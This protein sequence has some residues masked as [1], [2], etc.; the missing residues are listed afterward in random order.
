M[1]SDEKIMTNVQSGK[2]DSISILYDRY[3]DFL[4]NYFYRLCS[5]RQIS[6]DLT[7]NVFLRI[8][9][10]KTSFDNKMSFKSWAF[11]IARNQFYDYKDKIN[12]ETE[13]H[14]ELSNNNEVNE[15]ISDSLER[16]ERLENALNTLPIETKEILVL[17]KY[18]NFKYKDLAD[19][20][21]TSEGAIKVKIHRGI[22]EL[23]KKYFELL[24]L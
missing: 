5:N 6:E 1:I 2:I 11:Q 15:D 3:C 13:I 14:T 12:K 16:F 22:N 24:N 4:Y 19:I 18:R 10:Y 8:I 21:N 23:R 20:Y 17:A 7:Q 9:K